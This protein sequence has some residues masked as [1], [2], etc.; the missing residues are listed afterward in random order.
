MIVT[1][2]CLKDRWPA[3]IHHER[4]KIES[5]L[6]AR[7]VVYIAG[8]RSNF[9]PG[10]G[11]PRDALHQTLSMTPTKKFIWNACTPVWSRKDDED[12]YGV[13]VVFESMKKLAALMTA[14]VSRILD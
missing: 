5:R 6:K 8:S 12:D 11:L 3:S 2:D 13:E 14:P 9:S 7:A 10:H 1:Y 4:V